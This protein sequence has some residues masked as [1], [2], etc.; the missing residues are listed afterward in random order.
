[1]STPAPDNDPPVPTH[2]SPVEHPLRIFLSACGAV[3]LFA[4]MNML[5][6]Y[7]SADHS[8]PQ[9]LFFR[10]MLG[11]IPVSLLIWRNPAGWALLRTQRMGGHFMRSFVGVLS[12]SCFFWSF[13]LLPLADAT[14]IHFA[15]PLILTALSV[16][17]LKEKVGIHRWAAV[18]IGLGAVLFMLGP[19]GDGNLAG[20]L[21]ALSA[22][23]LSAFAM[24]AIRKLGSSE[25]ALT[26]VFYFTAF[27]TLFTGVAMAFAW[28]P[29]DWRSLWLLAG[30]GFF[31]GAGQ[32]FLTYAYA[33]AP[34]AYV[35]PFNYLAI[36][37]AAGFDILLWDKAPDWHIVLGSTVVIG[38]GLYIV[39]REARRKHIQRI[40]TSLYA[41]QPVRPTAQDRADR[42]AGAGAGKDAA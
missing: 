15:A 3:T 36:V 37:Y 41:L 16:P 32:V 14:S 6:K 10:N 9:L 42:Q 19:A 7:G 21:V 33:H 8:V 12:M 23:V 20:S 1:M 22:A 4:V 34:A 38:T 11:L 39:F 27:S 25:H 5:V 30:I 31:G 24:I 13:A 40:R 17:L 28:Q 26:I 2:E 29:L 18:I 35:S